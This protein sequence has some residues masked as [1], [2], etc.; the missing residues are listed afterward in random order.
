[1]NT[2]DGEFFNE[3]AQMGGLV[4]L[5]EYDSALM[6]PGDGFRLRVSELHAANKISDD[7]VRLMH[8]FV[9]AIAKRSADRYLFDKDF[10]AYPYQVFSYSQGRSG[11]KQLHIKFDAYPP[12]KLFPYPWGVSIGLCFDFRDERGISA[13]CVNEYETFYD[14]VCIAPELFDATFGSL[15]G[16][17]EPNEVFREPVTA[18]KALEVIPNILQNWLLFGQR[19]APDAITRIGSLEGFVDEC[20]RVFDVISEAGY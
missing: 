12:S 4:K 3:L 17:A 8:D 1:M 14:K 6:S 15:G 20:I 19:L 9:D 10:C 5:N 7:F 16:Y 11:R 13:E 18:E 2:F